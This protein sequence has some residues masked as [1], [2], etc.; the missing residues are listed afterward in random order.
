MQLVETF[1]FLSSGVSQE[2][3]TVFLQHPWIR[4]MEGKPG[5]PQILENQ[6]LQRFVLNPCVVVQRTSKQ[7]FIYL[8]YVLVRVV[9]I[10]VL[11]LKA[12]SIYFFF[13]LLALFLSGLDGYR[14]G[15]QH[16]AGSQGVLLW[17]A[18]TSN[19]IQVRWTWRR[20]SYHPCKMLKKYLAQS[21]QLWL[22]Y[23]L[24][25]LILYT[26]PTTHYFQVTPIC[27][28]YFLFVSFFIF[29][30]RPLARRKWKSAKSGWRISWPT[31]ASAGS[32]TCLR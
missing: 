22:N 12:L 18:E 30:A 31:D 14:F 21:N 32:T 7:S 27:P 1:Y 19:S 4:S 6:I 2:N 29:F 23:W 9:Y 10:N 25:D 20:W 28:H 11:Y 16:I 17:Y 5:Q 3:T 8:R 13:Y 24:E 26:L 15:N